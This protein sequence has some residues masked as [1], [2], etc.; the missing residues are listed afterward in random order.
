MIESEGGQIFNPTYRGFLTWAPRDNWQAPDKVVAAL[1][2]RP[3]Q[4]V[5]DVGAGN[6][7]FV[8]D[9]SAEVGAT[10]KVYATEVQ[11][12]MLRDLHTLVAEEQ[13]ANVEVVHG[14][15]DDPTLP[16]ACCDLVFFANV[17][18][19]IQ[20]REAYMRRVGAALRSGGRIAI[21]G[22]R[23]DVRGPGPPAGIRMSSEAVVDELAR[24]GFRLTAR[25]DFLSRQ[26]FLIF[27]PGESVGPVAIGE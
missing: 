12:I 17:Y 24:A 6:G 21:L 25:H 27:E 2:I 11:E 1:A 20:Q 10:G 18:K 3:G 9:L 7:Y 23:S 14:S 13:L 19:E 16:A 15:F 26:Y 22:F 4:V 5:A 8:D